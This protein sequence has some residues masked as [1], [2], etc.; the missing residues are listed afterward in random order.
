M[1]ENCLFSLSFVGERRER[2][3]SALKY[4]GS[5]GIRL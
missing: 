3:A 4:R 1:N 5:R 2:W